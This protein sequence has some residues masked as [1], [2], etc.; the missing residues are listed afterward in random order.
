MFGIDRRIITHFDYLIIITTLPIIL[1]SMR[2]IYEV[3][4]NLAI[5]QLVYFAITFFISFVIFIYPIKKYFWLIPLYY[6]IAII[7]LISTE[8][9]GVTKFGAQ[10]WIE[11]PFVGMSIQPSEIIKS[12]LVLMMAYNVNNNPPPREGY[13]LKE[14]LKHSFFIL[15]PTFLVKAQPDLGTAVLIFI[16]GY[17]VLFLVGINKKII[18]AIIAIILLSLPI[19]YNNLQDY[20]L[21]RIEQYLSD[22]PQYQVQQSMI[23]IGSG[24]MFGKAIENSTQAQLKFLPVPE[25]DFIFS[26]YMERFGFVGACV[27]LFLYGLL[28][29]HLFSLSYIYRNNRILQVLSASIGFLIFIHLSINIAMTIKLAP[30]VGIPLPFFSYGGSSFLTFGILF[31]I[32]QNLL[33]FRFIFEYNS[34]SSKIGKFL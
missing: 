33:A 28:L 7:L 8:F 9:I 25:S 2:L 27:L 15:L 20:Q 21:Q 13:N 16:M 22:K 3:D 11:I 1:I 32:V 12:A 17:G 31:A 24:G 29:L 23:A 10:R 5:K 30:V 6:W 14:F 18:I 34:F 4:Q 19:I 26:Y